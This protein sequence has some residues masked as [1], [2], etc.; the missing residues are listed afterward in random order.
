MNG[1]SVER[2]MEAK[3]EVAA[4]EAEEDKKEEETERKEEGGVSDAL[5]LRENIVFSGLR[6]QESS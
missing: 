6:I 4:G 3:A 2:R 1:E 5:R